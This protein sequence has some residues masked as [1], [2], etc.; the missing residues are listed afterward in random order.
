[1]YQLWSP[2]I[3]A[4][5]IGSEGGQDVE[6]ERLVEVVAAGERPLVLGRVEVGHR[7]DDVQLGL[8]AEVV[9]HP[10]RGL[11]PQGADLDDALRAP[12]AWSSGAM[13]TSHSGNMVVRPRF[14]R[15]TRKP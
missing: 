9:E 8:G 12:A 4:A 5:S 13:A 14:P 3:R 2:S 1:M 11:A 6:A 15:G 7:V 10:H